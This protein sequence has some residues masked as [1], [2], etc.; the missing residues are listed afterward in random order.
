MKKTLLI[1][2]AALAAGIISTQA[3]AV[4][5]QNIVGYVN[6]VLPGGNAYSQISVPLSGGT[7]ALE[8]V[9]PS[10]QTGDNVF[11]WT[12]GG[13]LV[14]TYVGPNWDGNGNTWADSNFNGVA[15]PVVTPGTG[16]FY[17]NG[18]SSIETNTFT[19][20]VVLTNSI[21]IPGGNAYTMLASTAPIADTL[22]GT[23]LALPFQTGDNVFIWT[24]GGYNVVTYVGPNWDGNGNTFADSN[25]NG[26]ASPV[27]KPGQGFFYQNGQAGSEVWNQNVVIH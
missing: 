22:D 2:V 14:L 11:I 9:M 25:F 8:G 27:I 20:T 19:G 18:Q 23:N 16:F 13:Y 21:T 12:G 7:N 15:S 4:Y 1:A 26:V 24:G 17:Q 10:I 5:S 6:T 3:Q